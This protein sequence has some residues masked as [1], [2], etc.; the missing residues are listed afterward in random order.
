MV[1]ALAEDIVFCSWTRHFT[2]T[3]PLSMHQGWETVNLMLGVTLRWTSIPCREEQQYSQSLDATETGISSGHTSHLG[4]YADFTFTL[5]QT[6]RT[7]G[8]KFSVKKVSTQVCLVRKKALILSSLV[9]GVYL[10]KVMTSKTN[11]CLLHVE[12]IH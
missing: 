3:V 6:R 4:S 2:L 5:T 7:I 9:V 1:R 11:L 10:Q 12:G 8:S